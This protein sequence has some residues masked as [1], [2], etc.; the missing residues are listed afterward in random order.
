MFGI[1]AFAACLI[2]FF[3]MEIR[4]I[5]RFEEEQVEAIALGPGLYLSDL[6]MLLP[7]LAY[8]LASKS[9]LQFTKK[10]V[11]FITVFSFLFGIAIW[12]VRDNP[13]YGIGGDLRLFLAL[14]SGLSLMALLPGTHRSLAASIAIASTFTLLLG[15]I[16]L[17][18]I[19]GVDF[20]YFTYRI[21]HPSIFILFGIPLAFVGPSIV[22]SSLIGDRKLNMLSWFNA[23]AFLTI[24]TFIIQTRSLFIVVMI[25]IILALVIMHVVSIHKK[26]ISEK[27]NVLA[28]PATVI[29]Y[30]II[31]VV[32]MPLLLRG[33]YGEFSARMLGIFEYD[34]D[35]GIY[36]R[37]LEIPAIFES[38]DIYDH[39]FGAGL[40]PEPI[41]LS[42]KGMSH[43]TAH[44]GIINIW[45][46]LG[47]IIFLT[48]VF[49]FIYLTARC[50]KKLVFLYFR[51][52]QNKIT[53]ETFFLMICWPGIAAVFFISCLSGG[54]AVSNMLSL[55]ML[56]GIYRIGSKMPGPYLEDSK[57][58]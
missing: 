47:F 11:L 27:D 15:I 20:I 46:R 48:V 12:S 45:W 31:F 21:Y 42:E 6:G 19:H 44:F 34:T 28:M 25:E 29:I 4:S 40:N 58:V 8:I 13:V 16:N 35:I 1:L 55:G 24:A 7:V 56:W 37:L 41:L 50:I 36:F 23:L 51:P 43:N 22:Y 38:M 53:A 30:L 9:K 14:F 52:L 54:W 26:R 17:L 10:R 3:E 5:G 39:I 57:K 33:H 2:M 32:A 49:M 18:T